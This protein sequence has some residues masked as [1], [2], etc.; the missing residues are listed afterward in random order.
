M[1]RNVRWRLPFVSLKGVSCRVD[2]YDNDWSGGITTLQ[3]SVSPFYFS[4]SNSDDL[5]NVIRTKTG[6]INVIESS[7]GELDSLRPQYGA[8]RYVEAYYGND[9]VFSGYLQAQ[10]FDSP[11]SDGIHEVSIPVTSQLGVLGG[12][13]FSPRYEAGM[14]EL[15]SF[16]KEICTSVGYSQVVYPASL[17]SGDV[18]ILD[19]RVNN[20]IISPYNPEYNYGA[21]ELMKPISYLEF[22][23]GFCNLYGLI[24]H[25]LSNGIGNT[26]FFSKFDYDGDYIVDTLSGSSRRSVV[27]QSS[28]T[29]TDLF[30]PSDTNGVLS[31]ILPKDKL[32]VENGEYVSECEMNLGYSNIDSRPA[33]Q[34]GSISGIGRVILLKPLSVSSG[35]EFY[36]PI[37]TDESGSISTVL[38]TEKLRVF[39]TGKMEGIEICHY[40]HDDESHELF[41]YTFS[42]FPRSAFFIRM[43][44][45]SLLFYF[46]MQVVSGGKYLHKRQYPSYGESTY[47]WDYGVSTLE[48]AYEDG[49]FV[50]G[51]SVIDEMS[52]LFGGI[53]K[54]DYPVTVKVLSM[55]NTGYQNDIISGMSL[56]PCEYTFDKYLGTMKSPLRTI[57]SPGQQNNASISMLFNDYIDNA[58]RIVGGHLAEEEDYG[59]LFR[60]IRKMRVNVKSNSTTFSAAN[61]YKDKLS[62]YS[63]GS[64]WRILSLGMDLWNDEYNL[65]MLK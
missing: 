31:T 1:A 64:G 38:G 37:W 21:N 16:I 54:T 48:P 25:D 50:L 7:V 10:S 47:Y 58:G 40:I 17:L 6:Y 60:S 22:V 8:E 32:D 2:I 5:L 19:V 29:F 65:M 34:E 42:N 52:S 9:M 20:R 35:N 13:K 15:D 51:D 43:P 36:S 56:V 18:N 30:L 41:E 45:V 63:Y 44:V 49:N 27:S 11:W 39:G 23:E 57:N 26:L 28:Y 62:V 59:Y 12:R 24:A 46:K 53:P 33:Y 3:G 14:D 55:P 61:I 4:E